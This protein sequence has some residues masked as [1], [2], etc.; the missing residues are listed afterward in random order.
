MSSNSKKEFV[1]RYR[2]A[3]KANLTREEFASYLGIKPDSVIRRRLEVQTSTGLDLPY[4]AS[5]PT[6]DGK[7]Q[8]SKVEKFEDVYAEYMDKDAPKTVD[9]TD[10]KKKVYVITAAQNAT[11]VHDGFL[12]SLLYYC[13]VRHAELMVIPYRY[14]NPTSI[15]TEHNKEN[16]YWWETVTPYLVHTKVRLHDG[17]ENGEGGLQLLGQ[18][19]MRPTATTPLSGFD[20][21]TGTDS[22]IFGH[23]K[24][25]LKTVATPSKKLPKILT[26]TGS[27]TIE[28]YTDSKTGHKGR[29]HH[30]ISA[31]IVEVDGD[32]FHMRHVHGEEDGS[33]YDLEYYYTPHG[34]NKYG[35]I[36]GLVPGDIHAEFVDPAVEAAMFLGPDSIAEVLNPEVVAYHDLEDFYRRNHHHR[37][38]DIVAYGKHHYKKDNVE[39]GLQLSADFVDRHTRP[40]TLNLIVRSNHDQA[41]ERWL[42]EADPKT[43]PENAR[44]YYYMKFHQLSNVVQTNS[45]YSTINAFKFWCEN[46]L[47]QKGLQN[48]E[49]TKFLG[50]DESFVVNGIEIG[51]HGDVGINGSRG[52]VQAFSKIGPKTIIGHS[53]S[54]GIVEGAYQVGVCAYLDLE[55]ASGPSSWLHTQCIIYPNGSRALI[56]VID[57]E[58]RAGYY[59]REASEL[60]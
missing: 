36:A 51:F 10:S 47:D 55:Y 46:P 53:H 21:F 14:T 48:L 27:C 43:D 18:I 58:W 54:P 20:A 11:P 3:L 25:Q 5:D 57:G 7:I 16:D 15:W 19:K 59:N 34:R 29:F 9:A 31:L 2:A 12:S 56:N 30:N 50:R 26:T 8:V 39:E 35:R 22:A 42:R 40:D 37:G 33:F 49:T 41:F 60:S 28:N 17:D 23:P 6:F 4:L 1:A 24:L 32:K 13:T 38:N 45:G 44:F 52:S